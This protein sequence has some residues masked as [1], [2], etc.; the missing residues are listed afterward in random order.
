MLTANST[1]GTPVYPA[2][3]HWYQAPTKPWMSQGACTLGGWLSNTQLTCPTVGN[4]LGKLRIM[5]HRSGVLECTL[6]ESFG[7]VGWG[8]GPSGCWRGKG[9]PSLR[10][11]RAVRAEAR[12]WDLRQ[13]PRPY[14]AHQARNLR[15]ARK[16]DGGSPS[17][18]SLSGPAFPEPKKL[19]E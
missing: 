16:R 11:V 14:G 12:S 8:C 1:A 19:G 15:N 6:A 4:N 17:A 10:R 13:D 5:P 7:A 18:G 3:G 2:G 9:P